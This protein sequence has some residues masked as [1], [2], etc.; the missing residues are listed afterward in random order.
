VTLRTLRGIALAG[1]PRRLV[2]DDGRYEHGFKVKS[3]I[4]WGPNFT[5]SGFGVLSYTDTIPTQAN[6]ANNEQ[7]AW[8][9]YDVG[10][11][12]LGNIQAVI[13]PDH[14]IQQDAFVHAVGAALSYLVVLEPITMS[15]PQAVLQLVKGKS[16]S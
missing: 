1:Q 12:N 14:V 13:D 8:C 6:A 11:T 16:Q 7:F 3:F 9:N 5:N 4:V 15:G 2:L 10:T